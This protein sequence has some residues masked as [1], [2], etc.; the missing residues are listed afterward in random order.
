MTTFK[1]WH[2]PTNHAET[3]ATRAKPLNQ[4]QIIVTGKNPGI[5]ALFNKWAIREGLKK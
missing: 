3:L 4:I 1:R 5:E 2:K